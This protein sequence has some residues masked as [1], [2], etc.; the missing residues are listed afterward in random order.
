MIG[1][2]RVS[3][4]LPIPDSRRASRLAARTRRERQRDRHRRIPRYARLWTRGGSFARD[5]DRL[6]CRRAS[7]GQRQAASH[8]LHA[9]RFAESEQARENSWHWSTST[10]R[11]MRRDHLRT[12]VRRSDRGNRPLRPIGQRAW[13]RC[14]RT[15]TPNGPTTA[16]LT[17]GMNAAWL[18]TGD[19]DCCNPLAARHHRSCSPTRCRA[20]GA[21]RAGDR[22]VLILE[23]RLEPVSQS[24]NRTIHT[25][26]C[27]EE[28]EA[29]SG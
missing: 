5:G 8:R 11:T 3:R 16:F 6:R 19:D 26:Y 29:S 7:A 15:S 17:Q 27:P 25:L 12:N 28:A 4:K 24:V 21:P 14:A 22:P 13:Y 2:P 18:W 10:C 1:R 23:T 20:V 9:F